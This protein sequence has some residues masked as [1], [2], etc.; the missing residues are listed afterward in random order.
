MCRF[1]ESSRTSYIFTTF[2]IQELNLRSYS[3]KEGLAACILEGKAF[4]SS[5]NSIDFFVSSYNFLNRQYIP[6][7]KGLAVFLFS[8]IHRATELSSDRNIYHVSCIFCFLY[9]VFNLSGR[10]DRV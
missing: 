8:Q 1:T 5:K 2:Q 3:N 10:N 4:F 7:Y 6:V 9:A